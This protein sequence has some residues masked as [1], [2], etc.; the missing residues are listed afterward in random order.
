MQ[1]NTMEQDGIGEETKDSDV[2][3]Q[4]GAFQRRRH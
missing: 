3:P 1:N 4:T 2:R